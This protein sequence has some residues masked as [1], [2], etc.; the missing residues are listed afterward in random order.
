MIAWAPGA[1]HVPSVDSLIVHIA[2][3]KALDSTDPAGLLVRR[4]SE[5]ILSPLAENGPS[6]H[7]IEAVIER[8]HKKNVLQTWIAVLRETAVDFEWCDMCHQGTSRL[9]RRFDGRIEVLPQDT[10]GNGRYLTRYPRCQ[11]PR[12][13]YASS[14]RENTVAPLPSVT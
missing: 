12:K 10:K 5:S 7:C 1:M 2:P 14:P 8:R 3:H 13:R 11:S 9:F 4:G 6:A